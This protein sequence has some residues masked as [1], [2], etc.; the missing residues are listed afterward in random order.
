M[1][2][3]LLTALLMASP[4][5]AETM[6]PEKDYA[7]T[8]F[9]R[10]QD[11]LPGAV[12]YYRQLP[13]GGGGLWGLG[14]ARNKIRKSSFKVDAHEDV[15]DFSPEIRCRKCHLQQTK[16]LHGLRMGITCVQ[17]HRS[18]P[19]AGIFHYYSA[20]NP[21]RRHAY[22]CAKCHEGASPSFASYMVHEPNPISAEAREGFPLLY[23]AVWFMLILAVGVFVVFLPYTALWWLREFFGKLKGR[24]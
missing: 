3:C 7:G 14:P 12:R 22:V 24:A 19:V 17:C 13:G 6:S 8:G 10:D 5:A 15:A 11:T 9:Y 23:Y 21:I 1:I 20:L 2:V 4:L 18:Q 16:D